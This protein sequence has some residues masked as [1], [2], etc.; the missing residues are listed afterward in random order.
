[1]AE[2]S[3]A[4]RP[5]VQEK[6]RR[7]IES[8]K[9]KVGRLAGVHQPNKPMACWLSRPCSRRR[10]APGQAC[11]LPALEMYPPVDYAGVGQSRAM[12]RVGRLE[13]QRAVPRALAG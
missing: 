8:A 13:R 5:E 3:L 1:M 4:D 11:P 12:P 10:H 2:I 9:I 7:R 6:L